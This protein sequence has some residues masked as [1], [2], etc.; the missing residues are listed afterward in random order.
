L[1]KI[2]IIGGIP[3]SLINFRGDLIKEWTALG[4]DVVALA[5]EASAQMEVKINRLGA[6]FRAIPLKRASL[7]PFSDLRSFR[8]IKRIIREEKPDLVFAYTI[9]PVLYGA[10]SLFFK[11]NISFYAMITGLGYTFIGEQPIQRLLRHLVVSLYK[12]ALKRCKV[13]FFQNKD[14]LVQFQKLNIVSTRNIAVITNG[15]G[16]NTGY[17]SFEK[18]ANQEEIA[19]LLL[20]R[21]LKSKGVREYVEA[22]K[23]IKQKY[24]QASFSLLGSLDASPDSIKADE[25]DRWISKGLVSYHPYTD[26]VRTHLKRCSVYVLP[27]YREGTPRSVLEAMAVGRPIITTDAPGCRETVTEGVNGFLVP[28]KNSNTLAEAMERFIREPALV[29]KMGRESRRIVEEK[30]DVHKVNV[31][32]NRAMGLI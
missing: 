12:T 30:Y 6:T 18:V 19:F 14:D 11:E 3:E 20:G 2:M 1:P 7:N 29:D 13:V 5:A 27:S 28:V 16:V 9:K 21:L 10:F 15:S 4:F 17:F 8:A 22:A 24:Q 31:V 23:I 26:D 25:L 32:I